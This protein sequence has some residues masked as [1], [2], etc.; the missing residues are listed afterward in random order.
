MNNRY[1]VDVT[2]VIDGDTFHGHLIIEDFDE[3]KRNQELRFIGVQAPERKMDGY[4]EAKEFVAQICEGAT[5]G[6]ALHGKD[7]F[8]RW[9]V[10]VFYKEEGIEKSLNV[11]LLRLGLAVVYKRK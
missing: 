10:D 11:E 2:R 1:S 6:V 8:G 7:V 9:L 5:L 3:V 4:Y